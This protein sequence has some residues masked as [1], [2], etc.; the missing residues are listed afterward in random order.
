MLYEGPS[1][2]GS[3]KGGGTEEAGFPEGGEKGQEGVGGPLPGAHGE[4]GW[5]QEEKATRLGSIANCVMDHFCKIYMK[6]LIMLVVILK[7][8]KKLL[9][10][11]FSLRIIRALLP[12]IIRLLHPQHLGGIWIGQD[13]NRLPLAPLNEFSEPWC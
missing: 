2:S 10:L 9:K 13:Q 11:N 12:I 4:S 7:I 8:V 5:G 3:S 6:F 1:W